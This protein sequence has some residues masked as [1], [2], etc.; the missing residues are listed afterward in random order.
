MTTKTYTAQVR[1]EDG[2][3]L[4]DVS[5][6]HAHTFARTLAKLREHAADAIALGLEVQRMDAGERDP[7][8]DR[9]TISVE[10][11]VKLPAPAKR[12]T[13]AA[14]RRREQA[15]AAEQDAAEATLEAVRQLSALGVSQRDQAELLKLSHQR[16][17][18][19]ARRRRPAQRGRAARRG[20]ALAG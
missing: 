20:R 17:G 1:L 7:H 19:L 3:W 6:F 12:A 9:G 13:T 5:E 14:L 16:V 11:Q 8:V 15:A 4:A 10:F 18:Q 2:Y